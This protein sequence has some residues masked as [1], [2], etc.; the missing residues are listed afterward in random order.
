MDMTTH[1]EYLIIIKQRSQRSFN[2]VTAMKYRNYKDLITVVL[3]I[4]T[5]KEK[6]N[7]EQELV[8][9]QHIQ[10]QSSSDNNIY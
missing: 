8:S 7:M 1:H 6:S 4:I 3:T 10:R 2:I 9:P 5:K